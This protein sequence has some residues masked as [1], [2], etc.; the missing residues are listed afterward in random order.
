M[1]TSVFE[2]S[3]FASGNILILNEKIALFN[4][5]K[6][7]SESVISLFDTFP[8]S[9]FRIF[10]PFSRDSFISASRLPMVSALIM[11]PCSSSSISIFVSF[12]ISPRIVS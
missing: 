1:V 3:S 11:I 12:F 4:G 6:V 7:A 10:I 9:A 5:S 8:I 2:S